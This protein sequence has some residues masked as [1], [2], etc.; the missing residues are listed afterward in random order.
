MKNIKLQT[1]HLVL[2]L[3][4]IANIL[5]LFL[6]RMDKGNYFI[7]IPIQL[8]NAVTFLLIWKRILTIRKHWNNTT[9]YIL[10]FI[11]LIVV[12]SVVYVV[13]NPFF[14]VS[15]F[16]KY[17]KLMLW[18]SAIIFFYEEILRNKINYFLFNM[19]VVTFIIS[20]VKKI[21][22]SSLFTSEKLGG[23]DT[24]SLPLLL[25]LPLVL[26]TFD[27]KVKLYVIGIISFLI[28]LSLR[29]TAI[30]G[31]LMCS[32]FIYK[33]LKINIK[34]YQILLFILIMSF[35]VFYGWDFISNEVFFRFKEMF[36]GRRIGSRTTYG[37]G[38]SEFYL[39]VWINWIKGSMLSIMF[40]NGLGSVSNL[41]KNYF[42][43]GHAHNDFL[44]IAYTF[45]LLGITIYTSFLFQ[46]YRIRRKLKEIC[47][48]S[49]NIL[50][51]AI[52]SYLIVAIFSGIILRITALPFAMTISI[53]LVKQTQPRK[54]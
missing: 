13:M 14:S 45:G 39:V 34:R 51:L 10:V 46:F 44:E 17:I 26:L 41:L 25:M 40:G 28:V 38:R 19:Y 4:I 11:G 48:E 42:G 5:E 16:S 6:P 23:G 9:K 7:R 47:P 1:Y 22:E 27:K 35:V 30:I 52:T 12:H 20:I 18:L 43:I 37:S 54:F 21:I 29:R 36:E 3:F 2:I 49:I 31:L 24:N 50:Y 33:Q 15:I 8:I 32:P 53:L